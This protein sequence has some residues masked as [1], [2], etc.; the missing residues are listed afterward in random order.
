MFNVSPELFPVCSDALFW[1]M[2]YGD[3]FFYVIPVCLEYS[4]TITNGSFHIRSTHFWPFLRLP[5]PICF[6]FDTFVDVY[7]RVKKC[8]FSAM[9]VERF[10]RY[11]LDKFGK[12]VVFRSDAT[13]QNNHNS[14]SAWSRK[15]V[16]SSF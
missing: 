2:F 8:Q 6:T 9:C 3:Y 11:D 13:Y 7:H 1:I 15:L 10:S 5:L 12:R 16:D 4:T 14:G